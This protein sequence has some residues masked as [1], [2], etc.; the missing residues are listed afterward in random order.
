MG[1]LLALSGKAREPL[2][3]LQRA[4]KIGGKWWHCWLN[5]LRQFSFPKLLSSSD[6]HSRAQLSSRQNHFLSGGQKVRKSDLL[7]VRRFRK[8]PHDVLVYRMWCVYRAYAHQSNIYL[9]AYMV[10]T[11]VIDAFVRGSCVSYKHLGYPAPG[12]T[13]TRHTWPQTF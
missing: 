5:R 7:Q 10:V 11:F 1:F 3:Y 13:L 4:R 8:S 6:G 12:A 9:Y 2:L